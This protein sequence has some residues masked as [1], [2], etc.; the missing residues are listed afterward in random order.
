[1]L[2]WLVHR[3]RHVK[4][5]LGAPYVVIE[6]LAN[7]MQSAN[8][9]ST[10]YQMRRS[11]MT[12]AIIVNRHDIVNRTIPELLAEDGYFKECKEFKPDDETH[13]K[14]F[15]KV[16]SGFGKDRKSAG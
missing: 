7:T 6:L 5:D 13:A 14:R 11:G 8:H 4:P 10:D 15:L 3:M 9:E 12:N 1:M 16:Q 2:P